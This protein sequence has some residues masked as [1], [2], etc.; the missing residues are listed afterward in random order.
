MSFEI[1]LFMM[2]M[3][4]GITIIGLKKRVKKAEDKVDE[5]KKEKEEGEK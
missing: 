3:V 2:F 1:W 5:L 4:L